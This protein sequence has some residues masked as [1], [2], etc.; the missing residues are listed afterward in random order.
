[1]PGWTKTRLS[2][3]AVKE[4]ILQTKLSLA[5]LALVLA[6]CGTAAAQDTR[7]VVE[8]QYPKACTVLRAKLTAPGGELALAD[9]HRLDTARLQSAIDNCAAG[10]AV[11]LR[12]EGGKNIFLSGPLHLKAGVTLVVSA[13]TA[14]FA[15]RDPRDYDLTPGSC[16]ILTAKGHGCKPLIAAE[17]APGSGVM[18]EGAIDGRGGAEMLGQKLTWWDLAHQAKVQDRQQNCMRLLRVDRSNNFT[19]YKITLRNSPNSHVDIFRTDGFTAWGVKIL[20]PKT[21]R[22]TDGIDPQSGTKNVTIAWSTIHTGDDNVSIKSDAS[23]AASNMS[24]L[25]NHFYTGHGMSIGS[26]TAGGVNHILVR[27]LTLDGTD[28]GLRIKSDRSR[29]GLVEDVT[30]EDVCIRNSANPLIFTPMYTTFVGEK[31]PVFRGITLRDVHVLTPGAFTFY[32]LDAQHKLGITL[33]NVTSEELQK[34]EVLANYADISIGG[35]RGNLIPAGPDV[36]VNGADATAGTPVACENRFV[37]LTTGS[38]APE[39]AVKVLPEDKTL[40][41]A[42]DGTGDYWSIQRAID[43]APAAGGA[44]I[45]VAP[46]TYREVLT[47]DK[48]NIQLRSANADASKTVVVFDRSAALNGGTFKTATVNVTADNFYAENITFQNDF[49][50]TKDPNITGSQAVALRVLG[51]QAIFHNV[52]LLALQDTLYAAS[53]GCTGEGANRTCRT[54]RQYFSDCYIEGHFDF[55]FGDGK[56]V[57][58]R[59]E[60]HSKPLSEGFITA[61]SKIYPQQDSGY[62][63]YKSRLTADPG[64]SSVWLGRPWRPYSTVTYIDTEMGAHIRPAG[65]RE[66]LPGTHSL[67]TSTYSEFGSTGPGAHK[68]ERDPHGKQLTAEEAKRFRPEEYLR[69]EDGWNPVMQKAPALE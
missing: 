50:V 41:V 60:I 14:L 66:W 52:R 23:G 34:S 6:V 33:D 39:A 21:A 24:I 30:F 1:V 62:V 53:K 9:E 61:Q 46:G 8:P 7:T 57:F 44:L 42:A 51:D 12:G 37:P 10:K 19:L 18:G 67:E 22:N 55:I 25:H 13:N 11:E 68:G 27:D 38:T 45:L 65:W 63:I 16:G 48:P 2:P 5:S 4:R 32:G 31:L 36:S 40:Y 15:S 58:D 59:C 54:A 64:V 28:N 3:R 49:K 35:K 56:T 69:G 29:G 47:I 17:D 43:V 20:T 26:Q